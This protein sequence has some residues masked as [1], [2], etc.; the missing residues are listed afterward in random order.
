MISSPSPSVKIQIV[1]RKVCLRHKGKTL[2]CIVNKVFVFKSLL[3]TPSNVLPLH[4][5]CPQFQFPLKLKVMGLNPGYLLKY[6][7]LYYWNHITPWN[8]H[9]CIKVSVRL[10]NFN[11]GG[12]QKVRFLAKNQHATNEKSLK[13]SYE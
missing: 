11:D 13:N 10:W 9:K 6:C 2:L 8:L 3:T 5:S 12:S 4:L 1:S 7:L